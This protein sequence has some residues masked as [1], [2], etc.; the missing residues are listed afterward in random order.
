MLPSDIWDG[1]GLDNISP[2]IDFHI[3]TPPKFGDSLQQQKNK[4]FLEMT[5]FFLRTGINVS[6]YLF[7]FDKISAV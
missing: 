7:A 1:Y 5:W 4:L 6:I 3:T 2:S